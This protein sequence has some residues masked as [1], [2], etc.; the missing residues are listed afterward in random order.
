FCRSY[1]PNSQLRQRQQPLYMK[2]VVGLGNPGPKYE[3][4]R[5]NVGFLAVDRLIDRWQAEG[6]QNRH[7]AELFVAR[8]H[9]EQVAIIKPQTF[10]NLSGR[11]VSAIATFYKV[12]PDD[13][14]VIHDELDLPAMTFKIKTGGGPGGH[15][16]LKSLDESFGAGKGG[17]HRI[18]V[19]VGQ[20]LL[21]SGKRISAE[22]HV[23]EEFSPQEL[24]DLD[25]LLDNVADAVEMILRGDLT[26]AMNQF[27]V[28]RKD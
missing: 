9:G 7:Q 24:Q 28:S 2:L 5:H 18:R 22:K 20:P 19:G 10:M 6:P 8:V 14:I 4:T 13:I 25:P 16:G 3:L 1:P 17:Y 27:N 21:P 26:R 15:N 12:A 23:L 11:A